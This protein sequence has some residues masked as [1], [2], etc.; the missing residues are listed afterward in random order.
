MA[1]MQDIC[2]LSRTDLNDDNKI[3]YPDLTLLKYGNN[4]IAIA[5]T[6]RPDLRYG[7]YSQ[8]FSDLA[9]TDDFPLTPEYQAPIAAYMTF[10]AETV[11]DEF[12]VEQ[13]A[14][15]GLKEYLFGLGLSGA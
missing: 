5:Y 9:L 12:A 11:D 1:K 8:V 7:N 14:L 2:D 10:R 15:A 3:R 13:R 6:V 4:G